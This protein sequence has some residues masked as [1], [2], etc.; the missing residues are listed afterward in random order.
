MY[1]KRSGQG[2]GPVSRPVRTSDRLR[3]RPKVYGRSYLY[4][5]PTIIRPK[6]RKTKTRTAA[7]QIAKMLRP[8]NRPMRTCPH[9]SS[10]ATNLRR[11]TR[12]RRISV[13]LEN[14]T[15]SSG[16]EDNDLMIPTYG[17]SRNQINHSANQDDFSFRKSKKILETRSLPRREGLRPRSSK[18]VPREQLIIE[19][20]DEQG[21]SE[22]KVDEDETENGNDVDDNDADGREGEDEGEDEGDGEDEREG[23]DED[24][25][26]GDEESEE[27]EGRRRYDLRNRADVQRF[28]FEEGKQRPRSPRRVLQQGMGT[29][30]GR[31]ARRGGSRVHKRHR[32]TRSE[33]SDDSL[34]V[35]ELDQGPP[36]PWGRNGSRSGPPWLLGGLDMHGTAAWGLNVAASGWSHQSDA[37]VNLTSGVQTAGPSSKGGA[38]IQPLQVDESVSFDDIGGLSD[39]IDA[40][41]EM[42]FFP[43]LYPDFF[44]S[45][46]INPPRGVLLCGPPGTGKTLIARAL[47]CAA[48][49]AGQKVSFY[50]RKGADVLS[51]W[52]G[53]AERQLKLLFEEAQRNQPSIIFFDEIDGLAPVRS[54]KQEQIHNS[55]VSTL[56][57][58]MDGLD[59]RGQV[60]LIGATN[61]VDA[62]DGALR[63]PG[64]FDREFNF[65]L[66]GCEARSEILDIHTRKWKQPPSNELKLELAASC[67]GY[68]GADLKALS[69]EA[70][71]RAFHEKYPQVYTSDDK[72]LIDVD[73]VKVEK[74]HFVEAM[75]TI[76][77]AAH[78]GSIVHYR[79]LSSVVAPCLQRHLKKAMNIISDIFPALEV[80]SEL[81]KLSMLSY[82]SA[83]PLVYR[84][85]L[86]LFGSE[87]VGLDHLGP[88]ILHELEKFPVHSL[89]LPSLLSDPSAKTPEEALV[90]IFGEA[91]R[92][93]PSILYLP[94]FHLW[95]ENAHEQLKAVLKTLLEELP[96]DFPILLLGTSVPVAELEEEPPSIFPQCN[97]YQVDKPSTEDRSMFFD[98]LI[99]VSL[100]IQSEEMRKKSEKLVSHSE[101][102]KAP[103]V[104]IGPK[105][106][107]LKAKAEAEQHALRRLR[108]CLRDICNRILYDKRFSAFHYP[109][110]DEDAPNYRSI[111]QNPMDMATLLQHV[112]SGKYITCKAFLEDFDLILLNAKIYNGD[113]YNGSR[114][115]SR[116]YELRDAVHG[117]LSQMDHALVAFCETIAAEGG[118]VRVPD[119]LASSS[120]P[121]TPVVQLAT[122]TRASARLRN[123]QPEVNLGQSYEALKRP[124]K[125]IDA[126][127][128]GEEGPHSQESSQD[129]EVDDTN[130]QGPESSFID[131][132]QLETAEKATGEDII[133]SDGDISGKA[134]SVKRIFME[135]TEGYAIPQLERLYTRVMKGVFETK[136]SEPSVD[137]LRPLILSF[138][139]KFADDVVKF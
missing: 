14:Y 136:A 20:E 72:F 127:H 98:C 88:A 75:S 134:E 79:P 124:K 93:T 123:V 126:A 5:T 104:D 96:S 2:D 37:L 48:S 3:R 130:P 8:G 33:D 1:S 11:S 18:A 106:S 63:R 135:R 39:Y 21:T 78:R 34:L 105:A 71:I 116:A 83:V 85:R 133:M 50:M 110:L 95:W 73:S 58:L 91:R 101:L 10:P 6:R 31:D 137:D 29:K 120:F 90:H 52:V 53:E 45:Y 57:A 132:D 13:N 65:P 84:P 86:L 111:I 87:G 109:V 43:L 36:I 26:D 38:D 16:T 46:H 40:L 30:V 35:D 32:L 64:R 51:K 59:S 114:I 68:C 108:M 55:I 138:L 76:T 60:V 22:D 82:V 28:S 139:L 118:P 49:K 70:A 42:V 128:A 62:I 92:T 119:E 112:D 67:V 89:G 69:T 103:K 74:Y 129:P 9:N 81:T 4:Y 121:V 41:K 61:R 117:M 102:P 19:S 113:D 27:Q 54:S 44:A 24:E 107:E 115:V 131:V 66:P 17:S 80:S 23:E 125:N 94:Q 25:E 100:S 77:P 56:L 15:D 97:I 47:A 7:S 99:E 122:V 12:R